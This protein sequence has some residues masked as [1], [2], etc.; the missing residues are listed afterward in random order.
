MCDLLPLLW[1]R[2]GAPMS[3]STM[4]CFR[5]FGFEVVPQRRENFR[6]IR[7]YL[8]CEGRTEGFYRVQQ[9][10]VFGSF[11]ICILRNLLPPLPRWA[12][13]CRCFNLEVVPLLWSWSV[14]PRWDIR[15]VAVASVS[16]FCLGAKKY[17]LLPLLRSRS[18][19]LLLGWK[20][21]QC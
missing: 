13:C 14:P 19:A 11:H 2:S 6:E 4:R 1:L 18:G 10:S 20:A 8:S 15:Y 3:K 21:G 12:I 7:K 5:C 16:K 17:D 9:Q